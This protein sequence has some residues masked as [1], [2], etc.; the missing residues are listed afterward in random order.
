MIWNNPIWTPATESLTKAGEGDGLMDFEGTLTNRFFTRRLARSWGLA[1]LLGLMVVGVSWETSFGQAT[2]QAAT[3]QYAAAVGLQRIESYEEAADAWAAFL[4]NYPNDSRAAHGQYYLGVCRYQQGKLAE[5]ADAL[6]KLIAAKGN[7]KFELL[8]SAYL[9]LGV[10]QFAMGSPDKPEAFR[11]AEATFKTLVEK[12]PQG[13]HHADALFYEAECAYVLSQKERAEQLYQKTA[14]TYPDHKLTPDVLYA[15]G[16]T[17]EE[18]GK[19][20]EAGKSYDRFLAKYRNHALA[21]EVF[22]RRGGTLFALDQAKDAIGYFAE[23]VAI[24]G[25]AMADLATFRQAEAFA[26]TRQ[27]VRAGDIYAAIRSKFPKSDHATSATLAAGK[28]YYLADRFDQAL[29][30][31]SDLLAAGGDTAAEAAHWTSRSLLRLGRAAEAFQMAER[32][33]NAAGDSSFAPA[34][35]MDQADALY[36]IPERR[37]ESVERYAALA[38]KY[39]KDES[40]PQA[41]YMAAFAALEK[42][43]N[44][45]AWKHASTFLT[46]F[47]KHERTPDVLHVAAEAQLQR[48]QPAEAEKLYRR[49]ATEYPDHPDT[50]LWRVRCAVAM[51]LQKKHAEAAALVTPAL[52]VIRDPALLAE[53]N[54]VLGRNLLDAGQPDKAVSHLVAALS[55][56]T[57]WRRADETWLALADSYHRQNQ[58]DKAVEAVNRLISDF[59]TSQLLDKAHYRLG[60][61]QSARKDF[62]AAEKA[63]TELVRRW[64]SSPLAP[65]ALHELGGAQLARKDPTSAENTMTTLLDKYAG[66][67]VALRARYIRGLARQQLK[68][69]APAIEDL[70]TVLAG[71]PPADLQADATYVLGLCQLG[72]EQNAEAA[73]TLAKLLETT[74]DYAG[75]ENARYQLAWA[76]LLSDR[77]KEAVAEFAKLAKE[78]PESVLAAEAQH[79][80]GEFFY[81]QKDYEKA[82]VAYYDAMEAAG[83]TALGEKA[84]HKLAWS[85]Y[86]KKDYPGA[87]QTFE[88]QVKTFPQGPLKADAQ[89]MIGECFFE[90]KKYAEALKAYGALAGLANKDFQALALLHGGESA[91]QLK[92]WE[93]SLKLLAKCSAQLPESQYLPQV[94]C[95]QGWALQNMGRPDEALK[96]YEQVI[97]KTGTETAAKAQFMIGEIQFAGKQHAEAVKSYFK[98]IYGYSVARWQSE[99]SYE[100]G[101]CFEVLG[102]QTQAVKMYEELVAKYPNAETT[103]AA[104]ERLAELKK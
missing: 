96:L 61:Y 82:A 66:H 57:P 5:A 2:E 43:K 23:A 93:E 104:R 4:K 65:H 35:L 85:Y 73:A 79:H 25:F 97:A 46:A 92:Q 24:E 81:S 41:L 21:G 53:A 45:E 60:E 86:H 48:N 55:S 50:Q 98:V 28:C 84:A 72:L 58:V 18:L 17:Q 30:V 78:S 10:S 51:Q 56:Q 99:A 32:A 38:A 36:E 34:L 59:P 71:K 83:K 76:L 75:A 39:P 33:A 20:A 31:L 8:D 67:E 70:R 91:G 37:A 74:P 47:N 49:L 13:K 7:E 15:L 11:Q 80:I 52:G 103:P 26:K 44:D 102:K 27:F 63:Y 14:Q 12:F 90:Q 6:A 54:H 95:E 62:S 3:R 77:R 89:F 16:V 40:A 29:V 94:L 19:Q 88:Y 9:F 100:A 101:R 87:L 42:G 1:F 64:A 69:F 68:K 22:V